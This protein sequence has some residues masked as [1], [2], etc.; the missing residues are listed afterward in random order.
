MDI[1]SRED[2][3]AFGT[4]IKEL[5]E[6]F[7]RD[8][9]PTMI[10]VYMQDLEDYSIDAVSRGVAYIRKNRLRKDGYPT[11]GD[12]VDAIR[13]ARPYQNQPQIEYVEPE[14]SDEESLYRSFMTKFLTRCIYKNFEQTKPEFLRFINEIYQKNRTFSIK[15]SAEKLVNKCSKERAIKLVEKYYNLDQRS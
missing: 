11:P 8:I 5:S 10:R 4:M 7:P 6:I 13:S 12:I 3:I 14:L 9:T 2:K 1:N 15:Y